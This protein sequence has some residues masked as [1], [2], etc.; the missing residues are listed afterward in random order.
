MFDRPSPVVHSARR[1]ARLQV[2]SP[3]L[4]PVLEL[5]QLSP[6][7]SSCEHIAG[8]LASAR[9]TA[10]SAAVS[11]SGGGSGAVAPWRR[12][13]S[14]CALE[15]PA[16]PASAVHCSVGGSTVD[17]IHSPAT[18]PQCSFLQVG[19][20]TIK[21]AAKPL[22][23]RFE[24]FVLGHPVARRKVID[25]AQVRCAVL[26]AVLCCRRS[27]SA[28]LVGVSCTRQ[29]MVKSWGPAGLCSSRG[30]WCSCWH[31][32]P[33]CCSQQWLHKLEVGIN[34]GA[35]GKTGKAFVGSMSE[36]KAVELAGKVVSEGFLYGVSGVCVMVRVGKMVGGRGM[37]STVPLVGLAVCRCGRGMQAAP[38]CA[39]PPAACH[40]FLLSYHACPPARQMGV[41]Q[42][43]MLPCLL[44]AIHFCSAY[45]FPAQLAPNP[46]C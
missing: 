30:L 45:Y 29:A 22:A 20:L 5:E 18:P 2:A 15:A 11:D 31:G 9:V 19:L 17:R 6:L 36:E 39:A 46:P 44:C 24:T 25:I 41:V 38:R 42:P 14:R 10:G 21:T 27:R 8:R 32:L 13:C 3:L 16:L 43:A 4:L 23:K 40:P 12:W 26:A 7:L 34:R 1:A 33:P 28:V 35:E 37:G